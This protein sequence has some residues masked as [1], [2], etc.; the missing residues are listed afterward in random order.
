MMGWDMFNTNSNNFSV[1][2]L[3]AL[4]SLLTATLT[5]NPFDTSTVRLLQIDLFV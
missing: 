1:D 2:V 4:V 5:F 3:N